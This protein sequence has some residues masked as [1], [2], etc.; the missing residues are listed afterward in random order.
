MIQISQ[1]LVEPQSLRVLLF[2]TG[3]AL[4]QR[5]KNLYMFVFPFI[6]RDQKK[7]L[8]RRQ[9]LSG[10]MFTICYSQL[11]AIVHCGGLGEYLYL[12][13]FIQLLTDQEINLLDTSEYNESQVRNKK[14][15]F[16]ELF[17]YRNNDQYYPQHILFL[18]IFRV[19]LS[20]HFIQS[21]CKPHID[22]FGEEIFADPRHAK[23]K[24]LYNQFKDGMD[25]YSHVRLFSFLL[26]RSLAQKDWTSPR[27]PPWR[28][29]R[30]LYQQ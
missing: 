8:Q 10:L 24:S 11:L 29:L 15:S 16:V 5:M 6:D 12:L 26:I 7:L 18:I 9:N 22:V 23:D 3:F 27:H 30:L 1:K 25:L 21:I 4:T 20:N 13:V 28:S 14:F 2:L 17:G 19:L